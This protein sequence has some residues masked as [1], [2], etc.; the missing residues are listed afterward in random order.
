MCTACHLHTPLRSSSLHLDICLLDL[1]A[2]RHFIQPLRNPRILVQRQTC[3]R[4]LSH[5]RLKMVVHG[6]DLA[7]NDAGPSRLPQLSLQHVEAS[8]GLCFVPCERVVILGRMIVPSPRQRC[9][10]LSEQSPYRNQFVCPSIGP[11]VVSRKYS[12]FSKSTTSCSFW[13][14]GPSFCCASYTRRM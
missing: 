10:S 2:A 9:S 4:V 7:G 3:I 12:H 8:V 6:G 11:S 13:L 1:F 5:P 14:T